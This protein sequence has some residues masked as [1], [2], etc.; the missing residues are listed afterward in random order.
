MAPSEPNL[1]WAAPAWSVR[2]AGHLAPHN[3]PVPR[4]ADARSG[5]GNPPARRQQRAARPQAV[6]HWTTSGCRD[7]EPSAGRHAGRGRAQPAPPRRGLA[8]RRSAALPWH[9]CAPVRRNSLRSSTVG[10]RR[11]SV[12]DA[13][14]ATADRR[15]ST[16]VRP[17]NARP[18]RRPAQ[19]DQTRSRR[20]RAALRC[21]GAPK[22]LRQNDPDRDARRSSHRA[23]EC[24][25]CAD[26]A[27]PHARPR[28][29]PAS[30][31]VR[32]VEPRLLA[33]LDDDC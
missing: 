19:D 25:G 2:I 16:T 33:G 18:E 26:M 20:S 17:H 12:M 29:T 10:G 22:P 8:D 6:Q 30:S 15:T 32:V 21:R 24:H 11:R 3:A 31:A 27:V 14:C 23:L 13:R 1:H 9:R 5:C 7:A 4:H 28:P